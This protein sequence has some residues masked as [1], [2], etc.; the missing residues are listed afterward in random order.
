MH[1]L[2]IASNALTAA[3]WPDI[4]RLLES[5]TPLRRLDIGWC[6]TTIDL[7]YSQWTAALP[8]PALKE[9]ILFGTNIGDADMH[10]IANA[11]EGNMTMEWLDL[12][13]NNITWRG[14]ADVARLVVST[15]LKHVDFIYHD[16]IFFHNEPSTQ[17]FISRIL[18]STILEQISGIDSYVLCS[19]FR[20]V[21]IHLAQVGLL[22]APSPPI[23]PHQQQQQ[24]YGSTTPTTSL[25]LIKTWHKAIA[26]FAVAGG[27][28]PGSNAGA[29]AIFTLF[30][31]R[32]Q[33]LE[34]RLRRPAA[35]AAVA[36]AT[37]VSQQQQQ[38][39]ASQ[40]DSSNRGG[41]RQKR[42]R[43]V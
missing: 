17:H 2:H 29:S 35:A 12:R 10:H 13:L 3:D 26:K 14:L 28:I 19:L 40:T 36:V 33:L 34:K 24:Q 43:R 22:L 18:T 42:Q 25:F 30:T 15:R 9:L 39:S 11:L 7:V 31:A 41:G 37:A 20:P 6:H 23:E 32:P 38:L 21:A 4:Q 16:E 27:P 8:Y 5:M 1:V